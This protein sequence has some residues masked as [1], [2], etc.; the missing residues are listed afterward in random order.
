[1]KTQKQ[2]TSEERESK[3]GFIEMSTRIRCFQKRVIYNDMKFHYNFRYHHSPVSI[4]YYIF[5]D[6]HSIS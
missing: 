1:V 2:G 3:K 4:N 5:A 6:L